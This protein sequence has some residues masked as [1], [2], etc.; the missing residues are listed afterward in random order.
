MERLMKGRTT[1]MIAHRL[2]TLRNADMII[3]VEDS[4]VLVERALAL[5]EVRAA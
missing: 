2:D 3:R 4:A 1:F 5:G